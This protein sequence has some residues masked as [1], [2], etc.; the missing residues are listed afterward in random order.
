MTSMSFCLKDIETDAAGAANL[1]Q[2]LY[3]FS[4]DRV[5]CFRILYIIYRII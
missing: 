4:S 5:C 3:V 1:P 2:V